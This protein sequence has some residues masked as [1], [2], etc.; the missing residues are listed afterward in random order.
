LDLGGAVKVAAQRCRKAAARVVAGS[1]VGTS[2]LEEPRELIGAIYFRALETLRCRNV[3]GYHGTI[4]DRLIEMREPAMWAPMVEAAGAK[5]Y[6]VV[7]TSDAVKDTCEHYLKQYGLESRVHYLSART[8]EAD[9]EQ[10]ELRGTNDGVSGRS[11]T[12]GDGDGFGYRVLANHV[13]RQKHSIRFVVDHLFGEA[14]LCLD[15]QHILQTVANEFARDQSNIICM[16]LREKTDSEHGGASASVSAGANASAS[17]SASDLS[18]S[19]DEVCDDDTGAPSY[20]VGSKITIWGED[21][22]H[23]GVV[24][25]HHATVVPTV[26]KFV[27]FNF[28]DGS[29]V[30]SLSE[31]EYNLRFVASEWID[32]FESNADVEVQSRVVEYT[33]DGRSITHKGRAVSDWYR[34]VAARINLERVLRNSVERLMF[35]YHELNP[36]SEMVT[37]DLPPVAVEAGDDCRTNVR[38]RF[39]EVPYDQRTIALHQRRSTR[40]ARY[41]SQISPICSAVLKC[42]T[43]MAMMPTAVD[44][45]AACYYL[46]KYFRKN[47]CKQKDLLVLYHKAKQLQKRYPSRAQDAI[48]DPE[49]RRAKNFVQ[50]IL[51]RANGDCEYTSTQVAQMLLGHESQYCSHGTCSLSVWLWWCLFGHGAGGVFFARCVLLLLIFR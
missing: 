13:P 23:L 3:F 4:L 25:R 49:R 51:N 18:C 43:E 11:V 27:S 48:T 9:R 47:S 5:L 37:I 15:E 30:R 42:N 2:G 10:A 50:K 6:H 24:A 36:P 17:A 19:E 38:G 46:A 29:G 41:Q 44:A 40:R 33:V 7:V 20:A 16:V 8:L 31:M 12:M 28:V 22:A 39:L 26:E 35:M 32:L 1:G 34:W 45:K 21:D 14:I